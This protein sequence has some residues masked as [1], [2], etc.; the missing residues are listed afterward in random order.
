[1]DARTSEGVS[2]RRTIAGALG[3]LAG[4]WLFVCSLLRPDGPAT[5]YNGVIAGAFIVTAAMGMAQARRGARYALAALGVWVLAS[6]GVLALSEAF[7]RRSYELVGVVLIVLGL[8]PNSAREAL[9][10]QTQLLH[11]R[12]LPK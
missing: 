8:L 1:M 6:V 3:A 7:T 4:I 9:L 10:H 2:E 12:P 5:F 11:R